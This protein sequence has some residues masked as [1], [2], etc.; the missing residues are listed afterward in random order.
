MIAITIICS[1][2]AVLCLLTGLILSRSG[3]SGGL[4]N[5]SGQDLEIFKKTKDRG[6]IKFFQILMFI[7]TII[8]ILI[9]II[10]KFVVS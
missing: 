9:A 8:L 4:T 2:L 6:I 10:V 1:I 3:S 7:M 5:L